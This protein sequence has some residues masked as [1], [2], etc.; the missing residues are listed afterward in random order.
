MINYVSMSNKKLLRII[1]E[2]IRSF[3]E[4]SYK[5]RGVGDTYFDRIL[6]Q[7]KSLEYLQRRPEFN[8]SGTLAGIIRTRGEDGKARKAVPVYLNPKNL[9]GFEPSVRGVLT[10]GVDLYI[11]QNA[12]ILH[13]DLFPYLKRIG[14]I[15]TDPGGG[16]GTLLSKE[17]IAV[18]RAFNADAFML[19]PS[20]HKNFPDY[21]KQLFDKAGMKFGF[22][23]VP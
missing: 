7:D 22:K 18:V 16:Y 23:F 1:K 9:T 2:E 6:S 15:Q 11:A 12:E 21:Y 10:D 13:E 20:Y 4:G 14:A 8:L 3:L 19:S 5:G 17:F